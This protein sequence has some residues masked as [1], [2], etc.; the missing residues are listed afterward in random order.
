MRV[1]CKEGNSLL[2]RI[3]YY[4]KLWQ[5]FKVQKERATSIQIKWRC[6]VMWKIFGAR[7]AWIVALMR[8]KVPPLNTCPCSPP[9][10]VRELSANFSHFAELVAAM[11]TRCAPSSRQHWRA[12]PPRAREHCPYQP[13]GSPYH[14]IFVRSVHSVE[15]CASLCSGTWTCLEAKAPRLIAM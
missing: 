6:V 5:L 8:S 2:L 3:P 11:I 10:V 7:P 12:W 13:S 14:C 4:L 9:R 15:G 1:R